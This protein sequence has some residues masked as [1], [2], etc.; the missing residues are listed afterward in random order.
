MES[1]GGDYTS[2]KAKVRAD[3]SSE[4]SDNLR[5]FAEEI[6]VAYD[7]LLKYRRVRVPLVLAADCQTFLFAF[8]AAF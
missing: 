5:A 2:T 1:K 6:D 4:N 3:L 8:L 7:T